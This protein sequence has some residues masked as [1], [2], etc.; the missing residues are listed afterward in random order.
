MLN[1]ADAARKSV[2]A[3]P[4]TPATGC[5]AVIDARVRQYVDARQHLLADAVSWLKTNR[6]VLDPAL[7]GKTISDCEV[8]A[9]RGMPKEY[10]DKYQGSVLSLDDLSCTKA[11]FTCGAPANVCFVNKIASRLG[12]ACDPNENKG[13]DLAVR[14]TGVQIR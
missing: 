10:E 5:A 13:N 12:L 7:R 8:D 14:A 1:I 6:A 3:V 11:L 4:A 9:C 2:A